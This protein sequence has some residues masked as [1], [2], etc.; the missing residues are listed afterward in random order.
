MR[1]FLA[2]TDAARAENAAL[3]IKRHPRTELYGFR[4]F[5]FV[6]QKTRLRI[7]VVDTELLQ[8][9]FAR[10][11]ADRAVERVVNQEKFHDAMPTFLHQRRIGANGH[12][13]GHIRCAANLRAWHPVDD[14]FAVLPELRFPIGPEPRKSHFDQTHPAIAWGA[15]LFVIAIPRHKNANLLARLDHPHAL[16]KLMP[17]A[18]NLD[19]QHW[20]CWFVRHLMNQ[21][22]RKTG[23][24]EAVGITKEDRDVHDRSEAH[25]RSVLSLTEQSQN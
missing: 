25:G 5:N 20:N 9:A 24:E 15:E 13:F 6:L 16:R 1:N 18:V 7:A 14:R 12:A 21:E 3:V 22:S 10:L 19:V 17:S 4:L 2:E 8:L 11:I 23:K